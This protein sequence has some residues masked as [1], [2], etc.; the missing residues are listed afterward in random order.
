MAPKQRFGL[1]SSA[2]PIAIG[3][4]GEYKIKK[5]NRDAEGLVIAGPRNFYTKKAKRGRDDSI[6]FEK[7]NYAM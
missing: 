6:Y 1:F 2:A 7:P 3:D 4:D 5:A